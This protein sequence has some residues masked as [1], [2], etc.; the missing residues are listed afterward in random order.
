MAT[1]GPPAYRVW[2]DDGDEPMELLAAHP[3]DAALYFCE[4]R[5]LDWGGVHFVA[6][7]VERIATGERFLIELAPEWVWV[8]TKVESGIIE[9]A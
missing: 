1:K 7:T 5:A 6:V 9:E 8:V 4:Q 3:R 2:R